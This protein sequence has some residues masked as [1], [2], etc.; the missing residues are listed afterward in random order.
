MNPRVT[1]PRLLKRAGSAVRTGLPR[2][3]AALTEGAA[4]GGDQAGDTVKKRGR[5]PLRVRNAAGS[6][7]IMVV[8]VG[9]PEDMIEPVLD[10]I[11]GDRNVT[12]IFVTD[13]DGFA[14]F[15]T[16][17]LAFEYLP[18]PVPRPDLDWQLYRLRRLALLRQK[19]Q[20]ARIV[21]FG[22]EASALL[23]AWRESPFED[24]GI[25]A[26]TGG[27]GTGSNAA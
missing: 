2:L 26:L 3:G 14:V 23:R 16:R 5:Q 6:V 19:W 27:A 21:A 10:Q 18:A 11:A 17:R 7:H 25:L 15:R 1:I 24:E 9:L 12:P 22:G 13:D 4:V 8:V 20:P